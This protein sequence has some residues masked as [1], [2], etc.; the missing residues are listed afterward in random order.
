MK[1]NPANINKPPKKRALRKYQIIVLV[2]VLLIAILVSLMGVLAYNVVKLY[3]MNLFSKSIVL[4]N[5]YFFSS[6]FEN[7]DT[8]DTQ[9]PT[10]DYYIQYLYGDEVYA[11]SAIVSHCDNPVIQGYSKKYMALLN[12]SVKSTDNYEIAERFED[13]KKFL[14]N[15][16]CSICEN[17]GLSEEGELEIERYVS[18]HLGYSVSLGLYDGYSVEVP[19]INQLDVGL[20]NG[21]ES[22]STVM[23]L[24]YYGFDISA[25]EFVDNYLPKEDIQIRWGCRYGPNPKE[26]YAGNPRTNAGWGCFAPVIEKSVSNYLPDGYSV[27]NVSGLSL[28]DLYGIYVLND[29]PVLIWATVEMGKIESFNIWQSHDKSETF[30]YPVNEHCLLLV[31]KSGNDYLFTDPLCENSIISYSA[32]ESNIAFAMMGKQA[33]IIEKNK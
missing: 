13:Q 10:A 19:H 2:L 18:A 1:K 3:R 20:P 12:E 17:Y 29:T 5:N 31:G 25:D 27:K 15:V 21:C 9:K 22:V 4:D 24:N 32:D 14:Y 7:N 16:I 6:V 23:L 26:F 8:E 30:L 11:D 28:E 33:L